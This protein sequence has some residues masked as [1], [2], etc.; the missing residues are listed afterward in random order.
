[1][2]DI[3]Q[4]KELYCKFKCP[5]KNVKVIFEEDSVFCDEC[6]HEIE[7]DNEA[8]INYCEYCQIDNLLN[9]LRYY[10]VIE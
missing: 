10:K 4:V 9:E 7:I 1:M 2:L 6:W 8:E 5:N 3:Q